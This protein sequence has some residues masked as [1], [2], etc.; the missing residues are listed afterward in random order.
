[1]NITDIK[2]YERLRHS[3]GEDETQDLIA[4]IKSETKNEFMDCKDVFLTKDDKLELMLMI[5]QDKVEL[6]NQIN[7]VEN[8][9]METKA[10]LNKSINAWGL[11]Q[12]LAIIVSIIAIITFMTK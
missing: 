8:R 3:L 10:E 5:K 9:L 7:H 6:V 2:M 4:F 11:V 12:L 1:M